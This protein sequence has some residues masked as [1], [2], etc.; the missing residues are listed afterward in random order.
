MALT[1]Q[2]AHLL[3]V[4]LL[5]K[6]IE[7]QI[8]VLPSTRAGLTANGTKDAEYINDFLTGMTKSYLEHHNN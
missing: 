2:Q 6:L 8:L 3:A 5:E 4:K 7:N 1:N